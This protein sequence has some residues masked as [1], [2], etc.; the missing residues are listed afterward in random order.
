MS[1]IPNSAMPHAGGTSTTANDT[2]KSSVK[3][4]TYGSDDARGSQQGD[5]YYADR[6]RRSGGLMEKA[7]DHKT[8]I[9]VG[10]AVGAIAAAAIP[11]MFSGKKKSSGNS[12]QYDSELYVDKGSAASTGS[13]LGS[14][15]MSGTTTTGSNGTTG[16]GGSTT[17]LGTS[18]AEAGPRRSGGYS[19]GSF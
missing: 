10:M 12:A 18:G 1:N 17:T 8:G 3:T 6:S 19:G 14:S 11:F 13:G 7:R 2:T 16:A 15:A 9:A 4:S 5:T